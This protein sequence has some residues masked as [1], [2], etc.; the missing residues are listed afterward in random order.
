M[1]SSSALGI[2][3]KDIFLAENG[4]TLLGVFGKREFEQTAA[5]LVRESQDAGHWV[6]HLLY[7]QAHRDSILGQMVGKGIISA[8]QV[9][10]GSWEYRLTPEA[11]GQIYLVQSESTIAQLQARLRRAQEESILSRIKRHL[12]GVFAPMSAGI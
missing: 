11:V 12:K 3:P 1:K 6:P 4:Q 2:K 5:Q 7:G 9:N 10:A 8:T